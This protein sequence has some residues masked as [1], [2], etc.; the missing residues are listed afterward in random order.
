M[1]VPLLVK[2]LIDGGA[3]NDYV[4]QQNAIFAIFLRDFHGVT[5]TPEDSVRRDVFKG[6]W[7]LTVDQVF[8]P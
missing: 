4:H 6:V 1:V 3:L 8:L 7:Y 5:Y 2:H